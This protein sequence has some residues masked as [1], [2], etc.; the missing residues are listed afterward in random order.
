M[1]KHI[2]ILKEVQA[3]GTL[4][5]YCGRSFRPMMLASRM[6]VALP[7]ARR[8]CRRCRAG[9]E[10]HQDDCFHALFPRYSRRPKRDPVDG[11]EVGRIV[12][13]DDVQH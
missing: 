3:D 8:G 5:V 6:V 12:L 11:R 1:A 10:S 4:A 7:A 9:W 2:H 13:A